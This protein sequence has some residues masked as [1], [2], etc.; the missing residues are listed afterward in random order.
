MSLCDDGRIR[1]ATATTAE[2]REIRHRVLRPGQPLG[3]LDSPDDERSVHLAAWDGDR[4]VGTVRILPAGHTGDPEAWQL[5][6]MAVDPEYQ[7]QGIGRRLLEAVVEEARRRGVG[8]LWANARTS[9]LGFY[10][11]AGWQAHGEEFLHPA[12]GLPHY[13][14]TRELRT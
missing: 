14:I 8:L 2:V 5:R 12:S 6:S 13:V 1:I 10:T 9:A 11:K 7:G 3:V 4:V